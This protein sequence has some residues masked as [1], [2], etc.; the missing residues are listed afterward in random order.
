MAP[1]D[2]QSMDDGSDSVLTPEHAVATLVGFCRELRR[3]GVTVPQNASITAARALLTVG[4]REEERVRAALKAS[5]LSDP[6]DVPPFEQLFPAFWHRLIHGGS[7]ENDRRKSIKEVDETESQPRPSDDLVEQT[8]SPEQTR[9][10]KSDTETTR[11]LAADR[12]GTVGTD[13]IADP[14]DRV[15]TARYSPTGSTEPVRLPVTN[16][17]LERTVGRLTPLLASERSR[18]WSHTGAGS[19]DTRR[20]LRESIS[21]GGTL[22][23]LPERE[24]TKRAVR[25]VVLVDVSRSVVDIIDRGFLIRFLRIVS[26]AWRSVR[27][28]FFDTDLREVTDSFQAPTDESAIAALSRAETEWGSGTRIGG[29]LQTLRRE[30]PTVIDRRTTVLL[31]SDGLETGEIDRIESGMMWLARTAERVLWL[32]PLA[33]SDAYEPTAR[34]M[35]AALPFVD[36][37]FAFSGPDDLTELARQLE[38]D[39]TSIGYEHTPK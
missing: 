11:S 22:V 25:A 4:I 29:T 33:A 23:S 1:D 20:A 21:T 26:D 8:E 30:F 31:V 2:N 35:A 13:S 7:M 28:F 34:G 18:R 9:S 17:P 16:E 27:I 36:G 19:V 14:T 3:A 15:S 38:Q 37:L 6:D 24:R 39:R 12:T 10:T 5:L 32:N